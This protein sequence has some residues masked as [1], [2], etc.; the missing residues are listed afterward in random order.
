MMGCTRVL[1]VMMQAQQITTFL[2]Q[3]LEAEEAPLVQAVLCIGI[4]KLL[5][6]GLIKDKKV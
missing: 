5:L 6:A 1:R 3:M 4:C 2:V